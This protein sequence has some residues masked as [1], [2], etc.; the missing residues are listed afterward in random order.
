MFKLSHK[1]FLNKSISG[2]HARSQAYFIQHSSK[3]L[4][5]FDVV[6]PLYAKI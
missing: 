5:K 1:K 6:N 4:K 2:L 3:E